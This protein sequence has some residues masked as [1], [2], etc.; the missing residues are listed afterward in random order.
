MGFDISWKNDIILAIA[1]GLKNKP[2][3]KEKF[4]NSLDPAT[5]DRIIRHE[6]WDSEPARLCYVTYLFMLRLPSE[7]LPLTR[8]LTDDRLL[9]TE[10]SSARSLIGLREFQGEQ[11]LIL[12]LAKRKN[13]RNAFIATRPCFCAMNALL[14]KHNC[15]IHRFWK[16]VLGHTKPGERLFPSSQWGNFPRVLRTVLSKLNIADSERYSSHCFR[17]GA[18]TAI[19]NSGATLS[20]I[21]RTGGWASSSFK[22]YLDL[23]RSEELSMRNVLAGASPVSQRSSSIASTSSVTSIP[24]EGQQ[25]DLVSGAIF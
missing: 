4:H 25:A 7:A 13:T 24:G 8:A 9:P 16:K 17:R 20:E 21:M 11:R 23:H 3:T 22:V 10:Q 6:S 14:P 12:K 5:L 19:L 15:P 1:K 2:G 18:A